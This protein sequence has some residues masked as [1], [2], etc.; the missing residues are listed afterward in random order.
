VH[1]LA[2]HRND[3]D[4]EEQQQIKT[5]AQKCRDRNFGDE[6]DIFVYFS[7]ELMNI[8]FLAQTM[9]ISMYFAVSW[10]EP[11]LRINESAP[12]WFEDR[13][14]PQDVSIFIIIVIYL[15]L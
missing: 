7:E 12:E 1:C 8:F 15:S 10:I 3:T 5:K 13:T 2:T 11:R 14:G 9:S 4:V 6:D